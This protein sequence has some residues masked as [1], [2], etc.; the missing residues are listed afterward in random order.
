MAE[1]FYSTKEKV[2]AYIQAAKD[3][4]SAGLI[5]KLKDHL[6]VNASLLELG[7]GPGTDWKLLS[8]TYQVTGSDFSEEFVKHLKL[9]NPKGQFLKIDASHIQAPSKFDGIYSNKV[10]H[11]LTDVQLE[12]SILSQYETLHNAGIL[13]H[14]FWKGTGTE[15]FNG[16]FVNYHNEENLRAQFSKQ[17]DILLLESYQ[18]FDEGDSLL[19][20]AKKNL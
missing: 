9:V 8:E 19:L 6:P 16:M 11:H 7:S 20:I 3:V 13:C 18:E 14:S 2:A 17:F 4:N 1:D 5:V 15:D 10:L 12:Q